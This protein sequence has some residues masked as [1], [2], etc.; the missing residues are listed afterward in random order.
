M[1][2]ISIVWYNWDINEK[3]AS[4]NAQGLSE[5]IYRLRQCAVTFGSVCNA[6]IV[7]GSLECYICPILWF[8]LVLYMS[9]IVIPIGVIYVPYCDSHWCY[10]CPVLW[11]PLVLY[12][13]GIGISIGVIY[14]RYCDSHWCYICPILWFPLVLYMSD[15]VIPIGVIYMSGIVLPIGVI[16]VWYCDS[17]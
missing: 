10:I 11:L 2:A 6:P 13:S 8:L 7:R 5:C 1:A 3:C 17:H 4:I 9:G 14:V 16:Y 15:I 12:M